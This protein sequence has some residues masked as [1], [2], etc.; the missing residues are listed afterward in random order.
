MEWPA[1]NCKLAGFMFQSDKSA[2]WGLWLVPRSQT[3]EVISFKLCQNFNIASA[4]LQ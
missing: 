3:R 4:W 1:Y 2:T